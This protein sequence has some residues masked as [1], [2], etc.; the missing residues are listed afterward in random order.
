MKI[1]T[2]TCHEV[3]N[4]GASL[5]EYALLKYLES[6]GH[7]SKTIQYK[8]D[9]LS[10]HFNLWIV[11]NTFF[12]KTIVLKIIYLILKFPKR[13][14]SLKRKER[15]DEFSN[16]YINSTSRLYKTNE[17]L[18]NNLPEADAFIC[19]S[20]QIWNSFFPNGKDPAFYLDFVP[21][22]KLK[23]SYA[24]S[25][26]INKLEDE[27]K[28]FVKEKV[29]NLDFISVR[30]LTGIDILK[31]LG[32]T[33]AVQVLDPVFLLDKAHWNKLS[34]TWID[35]DYIFV[36]DFE[37]NPSIKKFV[38]EL[39]IKYNC[40]I[41]TVNSNIN[42]AD[43]NYHLKGPRT[44]LSLIENAKFVVSNSF[45]AVAFS[46]IYQKQ[47]VVFNRSENL[48]SRMQDLIDLLGIP[49]VLINSNDNTGQKKL[50][51]I[52]Y[53]NLQPKLEILINF[54]KKYLIDSLEQNNNLL[55]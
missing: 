7:D 22:N 17:D 4:H 1:K 41:V 2:I 29:S 18:K 49:E 46:I 37:S 40:K 28:P 12:E 33:N 47:F 48:N 10:N 9:Y 43:K 24:A 52:N 44:F 38:K 3:Y 32:I 23:I 30:E 11:S 14:I 16:K 54:S 39:K 31:D 6:L 15:F 36:Y 35:G 21:N 19:G 20:D 34:E 8:P 13:F 55:K 5:Q 42:Y 25:F 27:I 53:S 51:N 45:H 50:F 26:A